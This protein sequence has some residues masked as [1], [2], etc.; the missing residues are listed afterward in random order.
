MVVIVVSG[1]PVCGSS[2][3]AKK[4]AR[5]LNLKYFSLGKEFKK[6]SKGKETHR[7]INTF[8]TKKGASK[9]F[10]KHLD[11]KQRRLAKKGNIVIDSKLGIYMLQD[12]AD[13]KIWLK[14]S[15]SAIARRVAKRERLSLKNAAKL[16]EQR[17]RIE[18]SN[19]RRIYGFDTFSQEK[20]ADLVI[21][22][23]KRTPQ[24]TINKILEYIKNK[25]KGSS[26]RYDS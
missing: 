24:Q 20:M 9:V 2:T 25:D 22:T 1:M 21:D 23:S 4:L 8:K 6:H 19:F 11:A 3:A 10:H 12:V 18:R 16:M 14:A 5:K 26:S 7:A 15:K 13:H 17:N